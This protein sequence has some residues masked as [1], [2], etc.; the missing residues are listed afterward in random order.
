MK[1]T[2]IERLEQQIEQLIREHL[3]ECTRRALQAV[4]RGFAGA[5]RP[6]PRR[7]EAGRRA[8]GQRRSAEEI[9]AL[10][11]RLAAAVCAKPGNAMVALAS[12]VGA[13]VKD[14]ERPAQRLKNSG[15]I[16]TVGERNATRYFP[17]PPRK[18]AG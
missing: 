14:L 2:D 5:K 11:E 12:E 7:V 13:S 3:V 4:E 18:S 16:R 15:R 1:T 9:D 8:V 17:L 6:P 10:A